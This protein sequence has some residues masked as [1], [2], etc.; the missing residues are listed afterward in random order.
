MTKTQRL[1][2]QILSQNPTDEQRDAIFA[3][4]TEFL[5]RASPGSGKTWTSCRRFIWRGANWEH[6]AGGLGLLSFTNTAIREFFEETIRVGRCDLLS[7]P[8]YVGTFDAF[9]ERFIIS[10]FGHLVMGVPTRPRLFLAA[11]PGDRSN[12]KLN[13]WIGL[14]DGKK[15]PVPAWEIVPFRR[16][17]KVC[18]RA[19]KAFGGVELLYSAVNPVDELFRLGFYT[20]AQ[21][22]Y[23][24][25]RILIN[26]PHIAGCIAR[27][28]PELIVD[29]AQDT[30]RWLLVLLHILRK[31]GARITLVGDPD[32]CIYEFSM[33]D[34]SSFDE[35]KRAW[36]IP[37]KPLS[38]S[39]GCN[40][41]I[42]EAARKIGG[43]AAFLGRGQGDNEFHRAF[44]VR[45]SSNGF[46]L[47]T[48]EFERLLQR[49]GIRKAGSAILCRGHD[50]LE[51]I[52]GEVNY[53][54]LEGLTKEMAQAAFWRDVRQDYRKAVN[55]VGKAIREMTRDPD[56]W[57]PLDD[58]PESQSARR[59]RLLIWKFAKCQEGLPAIHQAG[60]NWIDALK[61]GLLRL[62]TDLGIKDIPAMGQKIKRTGL[63]PSQLTLPLF[64]SCAMFPDIRQETIHQVKGESLEAVMLLGS[65]RFFGSVVKSIESGVA[66]EDSRL[67]YVAMTRARH[68]LLISLPASHFDKHAHKWVSWGFS[69]L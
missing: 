58:N 59:V 3:E 15:R 68:S 39:F 42:A 40:N 53:S 34:A 51:K 25:Y 69:I 8:N 45:E 50:Q 54:K 44:I 36:N 35:L 67:A 43:N 55:L 28:F 10:P 19:S 18:F 2:Q 26:R 29:E 46:D 22:I 4:D 37:E 21:R 12:K 6:K 24:A 30:N 61:K 47:S 5:L 48:S 62:F 64:K 20:H 33:A 14:K 1:R 31:N 23:L 56:F 11:R 65:E 57:Q 41:A 16:D 60:D 32:Q 27:R 17:G 38:R 66:C 9:V 49:A 63:V 13:G 7:D 52:H